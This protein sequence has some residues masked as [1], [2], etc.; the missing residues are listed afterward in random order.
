MLT[1]VLFL[2][3]WLRETAFAA[4]AA[5]PQTTIL[6]L[7]YWIFA[8]LLV[9]AT[10]IDFEHFIIPDEIT[11]GGAIASRFIL[12]LA[13][14]T[15][16][17]EESHFF[18]ALWSAVGALTGYLLLW[19]VVEVGKLVFRL[20]SF[21]PLSWLRKGQDADL[22][23]AEDEMLWSDFFVRGNEQ[24]LMECPWIE[25]DGERRENVSVRWTLDWI[26]AG[27]EKWQLEKTDEIKGD[28]TQVTFPREAMGFGDVKFMACIGAF[29]G[30][31][32]VLFTVMAGS[33]VGAVIGLLGLLAG[34]REWSAKIPFGPY[35]AFGALL[36]VFAG[37][38]IVQWYWQFAAIPK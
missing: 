7:P 13:I 30:W 27:D 14:P 8:S 16:Q 1:G 38:E 12:S 35:L 15:L 18:G 17:G 3:V 37:H 10:F 34:R 25:V 28:V 36:W 31:Q 6:A 4:P 9:V 33:V 32:A 2:A 19:G 26:H 5:W 20:S 22:K 21:N 24:V 23:V 11:W 29:L